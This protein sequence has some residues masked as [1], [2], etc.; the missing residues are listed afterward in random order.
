MFPFPPSLAFL[1]QRMPWYVGTHSSSIFVHG[2]PSRTGHLCQAMLALSGG[3]D[4]LLNPHLITGSKMCPPIPSPVELV[5]AV[6][7]FTVCFLSK[8]SNICT[9]VQFNK[10][11]SLGEM[12]MICVNITHGVFL[13]CGCLGGKD[14]ILFR[15][16]NLLSSLLLL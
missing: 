15:K 12:P 9:H 3:F 16:H 5:M 14:G 8:D 6:M 7:Y 11:C 13:Q 4:S 2:L 10:I 1:Q